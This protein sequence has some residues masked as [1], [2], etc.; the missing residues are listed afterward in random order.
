M[1]AIAFPCRLEKGLGRFRR[2][3]ESEEIAQS[4]RLILTTRRGERPLRPDFGTDLDQFA[5]EGINTTIKNLICREVTSSL[6]EWEPRI[7]DVTIDFPPSRKENQL[8]VQVTYH[9]MHNGQSGQITVPLD[10]R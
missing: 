4:V 7:T 3:T 1:S 9:V 10:K 6:L 2:L 8:L 5:F